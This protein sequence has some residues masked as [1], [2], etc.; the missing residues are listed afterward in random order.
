MKNANAIKKN[1]KLS[2]L[3]VMGLV[4]ASAGAQAA[5]LPKITVTGAIGNTVTTEGAALQ[6]DPS[7][8]FGKN[9][10]LEMTVDSAGL[11]GT[12]V[13]PDAAYPGLVL[14]KWSPI[15]MDYRLMIDGV[16][17]SASAVTYASLETFNDFTIL[18]G[19][20]G[21]PSEFVVGQ[22]YDGFIVSADGEPLGCQTGACEYFRTDFTYYWDSQVNAIANTELPNILSGAPFFSGGFG[23]MAIRFETT[24]FEAAGYIDSSVTSI[25][26]TAVPEPETYAMMLAGLGLV[27]FAARRRVA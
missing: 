27:G 22:T 3:A 4:L 14:N 2:S 19:L 7:A 18:S 11:V 25:T 20:A 16:L 17:V 9:Y 6:Y 23:N 12:T 24:S 21:V 8:W 13:P 26:V 1:V 15:K 5:V 10:T